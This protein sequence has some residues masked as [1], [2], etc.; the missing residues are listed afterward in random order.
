MAGGV[1]NQAA[2]PATPPWSWLSWAADRRRVGLCKSDEGGVQAPQAPVW[3]VGVK[4][5]A[6]GPSDL[7]PHPIPPDTHAHTQTGAF[8]PVF[9]TVFV[10]QIHLIKRDQMAELL[11]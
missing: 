7:M 2:A 10:K 5:Q 8:P 11:K 4:G 1:L 3:R 9:I 6:H